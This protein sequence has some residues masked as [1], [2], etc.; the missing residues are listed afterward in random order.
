MKPPT[1]IRPARSWS[2]MLALAAGCLMLL[3]TAS[4]TSARPF[5]SHT[6]AAPRAAIARLTPPRLA[7]AAARSTAAERSF[8]AQA[9]ALHRCLLA[10]S[11]SQASCSSSHAALQSAGQRL[12]IAARAFASIVRRTSGSPARARAAWVSW[13]TAPYV[14]VSGDT[15]RWQALDD[16]R[17]YVFVRK[18]AGQADQ[19]SLIRGTT[20]TP[21]PVP[22][23]TV[24]YSVRTAVPGS[25][26]APEV[27]I[28]YPS[29]G[30]QSESSDDQAAPALTVSG[31]TL[32][33]PAVDAVQN[34]VFVIKVP[35]R[36]DEYSVVSGT[37]VTPPVV[38]GATVKYSVRTEV[39]G[40]AWAP[41]LAIEYPA[42]Q[43]ES[44][45][46][47]QV[48]E[49]PSSPSGHLEAGV[50]SGTYSQDYTAVATLGA[51]LVRLPFQ[52]YESASQLEPAIA[53]YAEEGVRVL[54][55]ATFDGTLPSP[56][57]DRNLASWAAAF[58]P[59]GTFWAGRHEGAL[60]VQ[61]I[62]F[63][64][65]TSYSYQYADDSPSG[66]AARAQSY[67][68]SFVEAEQAIHAANASVGLL[69][70]GDAGNAGTLWVE[71]MFRAEPNLGQYV[72]GWTIHPYGPDLRGRVQALISETAAQ[73]APA[74]IPIDITEW[75]L[76]TDNGACV[77]ENYGWNRCMT[78]TEAG[79][80]LTR[81]VAE[82]RQL[83]GSRQGMF[84]L[85]TD[86]DWTPPGASENREA[87]F[88]ALQSSLAP[89]GAYTTAAEA[90]MSEGA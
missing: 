90:L 10:S 36:P 83:L 15:L 19:Y 71:N 44:P 80:I 51:H 11:G 22:G 3:L 21:P 30:S 43:H 14:V 42:E 65:E 79:E 69:A 8:L 55:L 5:N 18:V 9:R 77:Y 58:G 34:Y 25:L 39:E 64:N 74:S 81:N 85:Y 70:Q 24:R 40:S 87:Y 16:L 60:A 38:P 57:E 72:A 23:E 26:W 45:P 50:V 68:R 84:M 32:S 63:G 67:A 29:Q 20:I 61:S 37:S 7:A 27:S 73:G 78:Y 48:Q 17:S 89:K 49:E 6:S 1:S 33:W 13:R 75:G 47:K 66:Y 35:G 52:I 46:V 28:S 56:S 2:S 53:R 82:F 88:G 86:K 76:S 31:D 59:G 12:R 54:P 41:E 62:E 4:A